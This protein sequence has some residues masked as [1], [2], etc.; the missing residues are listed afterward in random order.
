MLADKYSGLMKKATQM[1][2]Y[3]DK[4]IAVEELEAL[5]EGG[6]TD[7]KRKKEASQHKEGRRFRE[8]LGELDRNLLRRSLNFDF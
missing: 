4:Q 5:F 1:I 6:S 7:K 3:I 8:P 2:N